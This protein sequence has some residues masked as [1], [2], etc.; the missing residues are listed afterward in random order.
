MKCVFFWEKRNWKEKKKKKRPRG[1]HEELR[2]SPYLFY[3]L[4]NWK[5]KVDPLW[6]QITFTPKN[7]QS[8]AKTSKFPV[9]LLIPP[10]LLKNIFYSLKILLFTKLF[11]PVYFYFIYLSDLEFWDLMLAVDYNSLHR[12]N[13]SAVCNSDLGT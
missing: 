8:K 10:L 1:I 11:L 7:I 6:S 13:F 5:A 12:L 9:S 2:C 4:F 3:S